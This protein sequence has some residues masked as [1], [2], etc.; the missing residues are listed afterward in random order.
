MA[1]I[2]SGEIDSIRLAEQGSAPATPASGY[3]QLYV[4]SDGKVYFKNDAGTEYDLTSGGGGGTT[5]A[6]GCRIKRTGGNVTM[7]TTGVAIPFDA[8]DDDTDGF[9]STSVNNTRMTVPSGGAGVYL[10]GCS[11]YAE[12]NFD[13][14]IRINGTTYV[15]LVRQTSYVVVAYMSGIPYRLADGDYVE[16]IGRGGSGSVDLVY[17]AGVSPVAWMYRIGT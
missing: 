1:K 8:E 17:D 9:H 2:S 14:R 6:M 4:K 15:G 5:A 10:I 16:I 13:F 12:Y 7:D 3:G 11:G